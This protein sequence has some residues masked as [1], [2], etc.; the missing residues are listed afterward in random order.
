MDEMN[1]LDVSSHAGHERRM[2]RTIAES[3]VYLFAGISG[4]LASYHIN[5]AA[6]K[7]TVYGGRIVHGVLLLGLVSAASSLYWSSVDGE[8]MTVSYGY[9]RVRFVDAVPIGETVEVRYRVTGSDQAKSLV[10][11]TATITNEAG[12][13][14]LAAV[15]LTKVRSFQ[16]A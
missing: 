1:L 10:H 5:H 16:P 14:V 3:D 15:H 7:D 8:G 6:M 2:A 13:T 11:S 9:D 4:D 12:D